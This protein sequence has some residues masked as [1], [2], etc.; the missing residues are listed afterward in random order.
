MV[1][2]TDAR[3][4]DSASAANMQPGICMLSF[5]SAFNKVAETF[6]RQ[7]THTAFFPPAR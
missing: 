1:T 5:R 7:N 3:L 4:S 6:H 2:H